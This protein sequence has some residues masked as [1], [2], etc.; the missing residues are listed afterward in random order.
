MTDDEPDER[1]H[2]AI[3]AVLLF[4]PVMWTARL[5][6]LWTPKSLAWPASTLAWML[7]IYW[8]PRRASF[9]LRHWLIIVSVSVLLILV[10]AILQPDLL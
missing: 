7:L 5:L 1:D 4:V 10:V 6:T 3:K 2:L 8:F 9:N